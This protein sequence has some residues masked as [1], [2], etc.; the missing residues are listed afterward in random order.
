MVEIKLPIYK[1][2]HVQQAGPSAPDAPHAANRDFSV[3][4]S[5]GSIVYVFTK[6][7]REVPSSAE[8][9]A[10]ASPNDRAALKLYTE[11]C[12]LAD[13]EGLNISDLEIG[14]ASQPEGMT[15]VT[16]RYIGRGESGPPFNPRALLLLVTLTLTEEELKDPD[17]ASVKDKFAAAALEALKKSGLSK[18]E[19][20]DAQEE[21]AKAVSLFRLSS[22]S[23]GSAIDI[24]I[25]MVM[26]NMARTKA[27]FFDKAIEQQKETE[28]LDKRSDEKKAEKKADIKSFLKK[29]DELRSALKGLEKALA[30]RSM[31]ASSAEINAFTG[32]VDRLLDELS[33]AG[34][35]ESAFQAVDSF[36]K[37]V[38][39]I[40]A[41][42][43]GKHASRG[44]AASINI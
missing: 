14:F 2:P 15:R 5:A 8:K 11:A 31:N 18:K 26:D 40:A 36:L 6:S 20:A 1:E 28:R 21:L 44:R 41:L 23:G 13:K 42:E 24:A 30:V 37:A 33:R 17:K 9:E 39:K 19:G 25:K 43:A 16:V 34:S 29:Q 3:V 32:A 4:K 38:N 12:S 27:R 7:V 35:P 22:F 10:Q